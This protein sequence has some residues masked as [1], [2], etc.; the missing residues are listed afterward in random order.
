MDYKKFGLTFIFS[1]LF[2][3]TSTALIVILIDPY[4]HYHKP[5]ANIHYRLNNERYQNDGIAKNFSYDALIIGTSMTE[6]FKTSEFDELFNVHSIKLP[7]SGSY[8]KE[9]NDLLL[10]ALNHNDN[11][12][13]VIRGLDYSIFYTEKDE[14]RYDASFYPIYL[15]NDN[16]FDDVRYVFNKNIFFLSLATLRNDKTTTFDEYA[17]WGDNF[18]YGKEAIQYER[19]E[20][21]PPKQLENIEVEQFAENI[22]QNIIS[23]VKKYPN[24]EFYI[25]YTPYS[26][27]QWDFYHRTGLLETIL[28]G[29]KMITER[30]LDYDYV[31]IFSFLDAHEVIENLN[32]Y[33][34]RAHYS[35]A[36][37]SFILNSM[38][39]GK[40][41]LTKENYEVYYRTMYSYYDNYDYDS[42]FQEE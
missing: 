33:K 3:L 17:Y 12:S 32:N 23:S 14:S 7:L 18:P 37:N 15:Y 30:L 8:F 34:D 22:E 21:K 1:F 28:E 11:I 36:V 31:H 41:E 6:N 20:Y 2:L 13:Y 29:E 38:K 9:S 25:F 40:H 4:F 19:P 16:V 35:P 5:F 26:I 42:L 27:Y 39:E 24:T 10:T